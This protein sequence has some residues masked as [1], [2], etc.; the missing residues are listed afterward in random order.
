MSGLIKAKR[1][2]DS[3]LIFT[4]SHEVTIS[5]DGILTMPNA[6]QFAWARG[7]CTM[8]ASWD[9]HCSHLRL[10]SSIYPDAALPHPTLSP[11]CFRVYPNHENGI[12]VPA[13]FMHR[14]LTSRNGVLIGMGKFFELWDADVLAD[15]LS[16]WP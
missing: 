11:L 9:R 7:P 10:G 13:V 8:L 2:H 12:K 16:T 6:V 1:N 15:Y 5:L 14:I 3:K 4:G